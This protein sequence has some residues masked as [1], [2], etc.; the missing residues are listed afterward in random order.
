MELIA[1]VEGSEHYSAL[2]AFLRSAS[3]R[4]FAHTGTGSFN[5]HYPGIKDELGRYARDLTLDERFELYRAFRKLTTNT[6]ENLV[7]SK[8]EYTLEKSFLTED[9]VNILILKNINE[10]KSQSELA[11]DVLL[12]SRPALSARIANIKD[13]ARIGAASVKL[14][15][16]NKHKVASTAHPVSLVLNLS[17]VYTLI[18]TLM[19]SAGQRQGGDPKAVIEQGLAEMVYSQLSGYAKEQV[20]PRLEAAGI[21]MEGGVS[22][23]F[24]GN[25][26]SAGRG[27]P[28]G[29]DRERV[30]NWVYFE[31]SGRTAR[32]TVSSGGT[33]R[34]LVGRIL[35]GTVP[36]EELAAT[37]PHANPASCFRLQLEDGSTEVLSWG[38]VVDVAKP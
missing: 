30:G 24:E 28:A 5:E 17:E 3:G 38:D 9:E 18:S 12:C 21:H 29:S 15:L 25:A 27:A 11:N 26:L 8:Q 10:P 16:R 36:A 31:K 35:P 14:E 4:R 13:G 33:A 7:A 2:A 22:P 32:V 23:R 20:D 19:A 1:Y 34:E 6:E 37:L